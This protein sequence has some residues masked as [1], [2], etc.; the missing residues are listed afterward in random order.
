MPTHAVLV[1]WQNMEPKVLPNFIAKATAKYGANF[2]RIYFDGS[3][4]TNLRN[5]VSGIPE[6]ERIKLFISGHGGVGIDYITR[7]GPGNLNSPIG[8]FP[9]Q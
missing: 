5:W 9:A 3:T 4:T 7:A 2:R 1:T 8:G 6:D